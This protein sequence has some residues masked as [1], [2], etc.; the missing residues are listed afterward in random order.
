MYKKLFTLLLLVLPCHL[1]AQKNL[2]K[3]FPEGFGP[4]EVGKRLAYRFVDRKHMLHAGKWI[5]Y[6]ET[7][8]WTGAL[9]YAA[10]TK[11]KTL[12]SLL[13]KRFEKLTSEEKQLLPIMNHVDL[14]MFGS[15]PLELYQITKDKR[16][17]EL[18]MPYADTQW[19]V[20]ENAT[21]TQKEWASKGFSWQTRL[22]ID[23]MYMIT[24]VQTQAYKVTGD[25]KY[26]DRA[27]KEMVLY[28]DELQRPNGLFYHAPDVPFYWGRGNGWMAA[29]MTEL[30]RLLPKNS[31]ERPR[32]LKGYETMMKSLKQYQSPTGM[33]NQLIDEPECWAETSGSAMF[34]YAMISGVKHGWLNKAEYAPVARKAW[35]A[36]VPYINDKGDVA[37]VCVGTNKKNDKQYYYDR[38]R[39][40]GDSHG[41]S[42]YLWCT[43]ALLEK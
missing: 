26:L 27:A 42:P 10:I 25:R 19:A 6:P 39:N 4:K 31:E 12:L 13:E 11:D 9:K 43:V 33:W 5:S 7:F 2:L 29:G 8:N 41:Q 21:P 38:P 3:D 15:L 16:Y 1:F 28:L 40:V 22:W 18:G 14:N 32:I 34:T 37:E 17:F 23:D 20:P 24:I 36:L 35:L 30:L